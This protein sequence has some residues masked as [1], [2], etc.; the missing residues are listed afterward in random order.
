MVEAGLAE[1]VALALREGRSVP[2]AP[3]LVPAS[4]AERELP[5][6]TT[7]GQERLWLFQRSQPGSTLYNIPLAAR[8]SGNA[9]GVSPC[10]TSSNDPTR[11][12]PERYAFIGSTSRGL[13]SIRSGGVLS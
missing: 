10:E 9:A 3:P 12:A 1:H 5:V 13:Q 11:S 8:L 6:P 7:F 2:A 4:L